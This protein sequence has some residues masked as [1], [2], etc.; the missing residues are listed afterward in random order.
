MNQVKF[1]LL[2]SISFSF[3]INSCISDNSSYDLTLNYTNKNLNRLYYGN[4]YYRINGVSDKSSATILKK[5]NSV[6]LIEKSKSFIDS[7]QTVSL[8]NKKIKFFLHDLIEFNAVP[9]SVKFNDYINKDFYYVPTFSVENLELF[10]NR[11]SKIYT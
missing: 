1:I 7:Y 5:P 11:S 8:I 9:I 2:L 4:D 10:K 3:F 6:L